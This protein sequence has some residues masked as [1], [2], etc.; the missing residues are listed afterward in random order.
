MVYPYLDGYSYKYYFD[1][2]IRACPPL[3]FNLSE[4]LLLKI[5]NL[6]PKMSVLQTSWDKIEMPSSHNFYLQ[7]FQLSVGKLQFPAPFSVFVY[8]RRQP[9]SVYKATER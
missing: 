8:M 9:E 4:N 2:I 7:N 3:Q 5:Q 1:S 6:G